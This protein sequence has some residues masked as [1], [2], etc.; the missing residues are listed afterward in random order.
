LI[1]SGYYNDHHF[2]YGYH[3]YA[4]AVVAKYDPEWGREYFDRVMLFV[5]DIATPSPNDKFFTQFRQKD[6]YL[7]SSWASGIISA[8]NSPHGRNEESSSEAIAAY[9]GVAL[10]G[11]VMMDIFG[12]SSKKGDSNKQLVAKDVR[13]IGQ[14]LTVTEVR[15]AN[16]YWHVWNSPT[17]KSTYPSEYKEHAVGMLYETMASFQTWFSPAAFVSYGIQL[18]PLTPVAE[19]RDDP[20]WAA[21]LYPMYKKSCSAQQKFC[22]N[23]GWSILELSLLATAGKPDEALKAV[24]MIPKDVFASQ[25]ACGNSLTNTIW[26]MSTRKPVDIKMGND[27]NTDLLN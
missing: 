24:S 1:L 25:G 21:E 6:F 4:A 26:F 27:T 9:E 10:Y 18:L 23:Q 11:Q 20:E 19:I 7:G 3:I 12:K 15:A 14:F 17:H 5:R 13:D 2:H 16:R 8:E 22:T